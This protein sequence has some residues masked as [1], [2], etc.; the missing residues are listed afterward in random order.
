[1]IDNICAISTPFGRAALGVIRVSGP[2]VEA[3]ARRMTGASPKVR[4]PI[5]TTIRDSSGHIIDEC[6][7]TLYKSPNSYTGEDLLEICA[8]GNPVILNE[9][10]AE[11]VSRETFRL[12]EPGEF[13]AR[14]LANRKMTL[15]QVEAM[16]WILNSKTLEGV[17]RGLS[18]KL[19]G[20]GVQVSKASEQLLRIL[21]I[22]QSQLDFSEDEVGGTNLREVRAALEELIATLSHWEASYVSNRHLLD[23]FRV[24]IIGPPNSGKSSLF[25]ALI[26]KDKSIVFDQPGTTRDYIE[27]VL[28][29]EGRE[30]S[31]VDTAGIRESSDPIE[32][33]GIKKSLEEAHRAD[34]ILWVDENGDGANLE[35]PFLSPLKGKTL[36]VQS[37]IDRSEPVSRPGWAPCS[38]ITGDGVNELKRMISQRWIVAEPE[39]E[40]SALTSDRQFNIVKKTLILVRRA[41]QDLEAGAY[42]EVVAESVIRASRN[43]SA[44]IDVPSD[45]EVL[46]SIFSRFCIGK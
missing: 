3:L 37:K 1:M 17:R 6:V 43:L 44:L 25:N 33:I 27:G 30:V 28:V 26:G 45:V 32:F 15:D 19:R 4:T 24:V 23:G 20:I 22:L 11:I 21:S 39:A 2:N 41:T 12:A 38:V 5:L 34:L 8:H 16:D 18:A 42:L 29:V 46:K 10:I 7:M 14:A 35:S 31:L 9:V 13:S 36:M 40:G